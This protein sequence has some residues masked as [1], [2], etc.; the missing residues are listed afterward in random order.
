MAEQLPESMEKLL[1]DED[2]DYSEAQFLSLY[3]K[4]EKEGR[5]PHSIG[6]GLLRVLLQISSDM[7][8]LSHDR[9]FLEHASE[10]V[11]K[12]IDIINDAV[13]INKP[14]H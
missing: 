1:R 9:K 13:G 4:L 8:T 14:K 12:S 11:N 5:D 2:G 6:R 3:R 10:V 7:P